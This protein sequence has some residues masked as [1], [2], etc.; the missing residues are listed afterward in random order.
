MVCFL[1]FSLYIDVFFIIVVKC[2]ANVLTL[3]L[4][5]HGPRMGM[6]ITVLILFQIAL[7]GAYIMY[8]RRRAN[9]PKK[10]L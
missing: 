3:A 4:L 9:A 1:S 2:V 5:S 7:V 6:G 8:K 10:Y